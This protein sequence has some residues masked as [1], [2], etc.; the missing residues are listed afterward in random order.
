MGHKFRKDFFVA[1]VERDVAPLKYF[2]GAS[3]LE[4]QSPQP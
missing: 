1:R 4:D 3:L 2:L